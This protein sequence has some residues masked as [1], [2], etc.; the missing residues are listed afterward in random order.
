M[1]GNYHPKEPLHSFASYQR[2]NKRD[3][4]LIFINKAA[5]YEM[6]F[7]SDASSTATKSTK[8]Q[9]VKIDLSPAFLMLSD[10]FLIYKCAAFQ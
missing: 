10:H 7:S 9:Y 3:P 5:F 1:A 6:Y 2:R 8:K 4:S